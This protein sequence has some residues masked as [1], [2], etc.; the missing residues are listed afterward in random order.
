MRI[1]MRDELLETILHSYRNLREEINKL[2]CE[3]KDIKNGLQDLKFL[4]NDSIS[5][6]REL[7]TR[8][9]EV[10]NNLN[11]NKINS[12]LNINNKKLIE[13][14]VSSTNRVITVKEKKSLK[15]EKKACQV[16]N[17]QKLSLEAKQKTQ[18]VLRD[19]YLN[20][21]FTELEIEVNN[22]F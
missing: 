4:I 7:K 14:P 13:S 9:D 16:L 11:I 21:T 5:N 15:K 20:K 19:F 8:N 18:T 3:T 10:I 22:Q 1:N 2:R 6:I 12:N 17:N